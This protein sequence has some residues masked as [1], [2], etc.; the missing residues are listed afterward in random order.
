MFGGY[1]QVAQDGQ[2]GQ[3]GQVS[4]ASIPLMRTIYL[5]LN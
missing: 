2:D 3:D 5:M 1:Q 4:F